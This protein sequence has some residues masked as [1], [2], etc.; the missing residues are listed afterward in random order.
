MEQFTMEK[1]KSFEL[2]GEESY[3]SDKTKKGS[4]PYTYGLAKTALL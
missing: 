2:F 1:V 4:P 3:D